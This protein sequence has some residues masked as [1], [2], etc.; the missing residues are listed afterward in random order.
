MPNQQ[1]LIMR[2][3]SELSQ[4]NNQGTENFYIAR[5]Q[6][7]F[8]ARE[9]DRTKGQVLRPR[10][11]INTLCK[12]SFVAIWRYQ[13]ESRSRGGAF[14]SWKALVGKP[15]TLTVLRSLS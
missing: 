1:N 9:T 6:L 12:G 11:L 4:C 14:I 13:R 3:P 10:S 5:V 7:D 8:R 15:P 2:F